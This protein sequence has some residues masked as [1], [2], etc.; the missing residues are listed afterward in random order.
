MKVI[1]PIILTDSHL[2][3]STVAETDAD[4]GPQWAP[5]TSYAIGAMV[6]NLH[7]RYQRLIPGAT[8]ALPGDDAINWLPLG[9]TNRWRML[10]ADGDYKTTGTS[11]MVVVIKPLV[12]AAALAIIGMVA[13]SIT[14][15]QKDASGAVVLTFTQNLTYRNTTTWSEYYFG[16]FLKRS[17]F[18]TTDLLQITGASITITLTSITGVVSCG[19]IAIGTPVDLGKILEGSASVGALSFSR[20]ERNDFG[21]SLVT[22]RRTVPRTSQTTM[23]PK[24]NVEKARVTLTALDGTTAMFVGIPDNTSGYFNALCVLG[25]VK[26]WDI[27]LDSFNR[28]ELQI[29]LEGL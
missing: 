25:L 24:A 29:D 6:R 2:F 20:V 21:D 16:A 8:A 13:D 19:A 14:V 7:R 23:I 27:K 28:G 3:S 22:K 15:V 12:R 18:V 9:A 1:P 10:A 4:D 17:A 26:Q 11:P 5:G